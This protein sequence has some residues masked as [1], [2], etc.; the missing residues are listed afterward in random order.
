MSSPQNRSQIEGPEQQELRNM[1]VTFYDTHLYRGNS[2]D[3]TQLFTLQDKAEALSYFDAA[4]NS[5]SG[6]E[7][8]LRRIRSLL[9]REQ[10]K[11]FAIQQKRNFIASLHALDIALDTK[12]ELQAEFFASSFKGKADLLRFVKTEEKRIS[13]K[14]L[15]QI[16]E[17]ESYKASYWAFFESHRE[18]FCYED[19]VSAWNYVVVSLAG[20]RTHAAKMRRLQMV[21]AM[22]P[23]N[24]A[25]AKSL[26]EEYQRLLH[27]HIDNDERRNACLNAFRLCTFKN[28]LDRINEIKTTPTLEQK[29]QKLEQEKYEQWVIYKNLYAA[30]PHGISPDDFSELTLVEQKKI[31]EQKRSNNNEEQELLKEYLNL[32]DINEDQT[33]AFKKLV[34]SSKKEKIQQKKAAMAQEAAAANKPKHE[35]EI[36]QLSVVPIK[37][38]KICL[39][40]AQILRNQ[41]RHIYVD[42]GDRVKAI[43]KK[44]I[45]E[46][47]TGD[48]TLQHLQ[49]IQ[50]LLSQFSTDEYENPGTLQWVELELKKQIYVG[51]SSKGQSSTQTRSNVRNTMG[52]KL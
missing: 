42:D 21:I 44:M 36:V 13:T 3:D 30:F 32:G 39:I 28:K 6:E 17:R 25:Y 35:A 23:S 26:D 46:S 45:A 33:E 22:L 41:E 29:R 19:Q 48:F 51:E 2:S 12:V 20:V 24:L 47:V 31:I 37:P 10:T 1:L 5:V 34:I 9:L 11:A 14:K 27:R 50:S 18:Y 7:L 8:T 38:L 49:I 43:K 52:K 15:L 40:A 16:Q 4:D